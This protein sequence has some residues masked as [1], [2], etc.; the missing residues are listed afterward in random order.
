MTT[1]PAAPPAPAV[2]VRGSAPAAPAPVP[3]KKSPAR[4]IPVAIPLNLTTGVDPGPD[5]IVIYGTGGI[6]KSTLAAWLPAPIFLDTEKSTKK[7]PVAREYVGSWPELR[8]KIAAIEASPPQGARSVVIDTVSVAEELA[9]EYVIE[10]RRTEKGNAVDSIEGFGWGKGWKFVYEEFNA[11]LADLD[12][13]NAKGLVV[14]LTAHVVAAVV[15]NPAGDDWLQWQPFLYPGDKKGDANI[16]NR[17][18][19]WAEQVLFIG[20]DTFVP[21]GTGKAQGSGTRTIYTGELPTHIAKSRSK[22]L[23]ISYD[24]QDPSAVWRELGII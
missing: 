20:Y 3:I 18:K 15:P 22:A 6:G 8:G 5:R 9:R 17:V 7:L 2:P 23:T 19:N 1:R 10:T 14:C 4:T 24:L 21:D 13:L 11:L 16:R 12:R